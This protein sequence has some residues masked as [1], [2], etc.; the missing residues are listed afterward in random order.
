MQVIGAMRN[1]LEV[2]SVILL[3]EVKAW[4]KEM[5][6]FVN[7]LDSKYCLT[8]GLEGF[9]GPTT[10]DKAM[11]FP[12]LKLQSNCVD[13]QRCV[14]FEVL[15]EKDLTRSPSHSWWKRLKMVFGVDA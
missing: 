8:V 14:G 4:M 15:E 9:Y 3:C 13:R 10:P 11:C 2:V 6:E 7:S 5:A 1:Y 12:D